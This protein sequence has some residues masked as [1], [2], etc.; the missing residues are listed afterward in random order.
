MANNIDD[1]ILSSWGNISGI[2]GP[3][4]IEVFK[5]SRITLR[6]TLKKPK[7]FPAFLVMLRSS[8]SPR[9]GSPCFPKKRMARTICRIM[10]LFS[11]IRIWIS[12]LAITSIR[13][14]GW[15][16]L[17]LKISV[18]CIKSRRYRR[19]EWLLKEFHIFDQL[20]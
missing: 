10:C 4:F 9:N 20:E 1:L 12:L 17:F 19:E 11:S 18:Y 5:K 7:K 15:S 16:I 6:K 14:A 3:L 8:Q 13:Q 2:L